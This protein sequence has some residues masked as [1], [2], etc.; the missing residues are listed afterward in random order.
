[1]S[2]RKILIF[3]NQHLGIELI[4]YI[5]SQ[6]RDEI[7]GIVC[8][9]DGYDKGEKPWYPSI[10][11]FAQKK[12]LKVFNPR[13]LRNKTF[14]ENVKKLA[15]DII[16]SASYR[17]MIPYECF[18]MAKIAGFNIHG[19]LLPKN[20]G[21]APLNWALIKGENEG[22]STAHFLV[23]KADQGNIIA[24]KKFLITKN[25]DA[26][27]VYKKM[28]RTDLAVAKEALKKLKNKNFKG[29]KQDKKKA[30]YNPPRRPDDGKIDWNNSAQNIYNF[31]R[32]LVKPYPGAFSYYKN[33]KIFIWKASVTNSLIKGVPGR[34]AAVKA[35]TP[36][37]E[38]GA[39]L[40]KILD[41]KIVKKIKIQFK[42]GERFH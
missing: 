42:I 32:A 31:I 1:M 34:I 8:H 20:R 29:Q 13:N 7:I 9:P 10:K 28:L 39:G 14:L 36:I 12:N 18:K 37:I 27:T 40:L 11:M 6:K 33:H 24:Q 22:G 4:K 5:L 19:S 35:D 21:W 26:K 38:T 2:K 16:I 23:E 41:Y 30:S 15:P 17:L 3:G 25:D